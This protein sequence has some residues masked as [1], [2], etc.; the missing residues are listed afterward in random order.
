MRL[1]A[2]VRVCPHCGQVFTAEEVEALLPDL[3]KV[4]FNE[5]EPP[6]T[7]DVDRMLVCFHVS[8]AS[9]KRMLRVDF[10]D[11]AIF[12]GEKTSAYLGFSDEYS[13]F[14]LEKSAALWGQICPDYPMPD[15]AEEAF[16]VQKMMI[17]PSQV[18]YQREGKFKNILE[19]IFTE[20]QEA[21]SLD[22]VPF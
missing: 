1:H 20:K 2:S 12:G 13:G 14:F 18:I 5:P 7:I 17:Q 4:T 19:L 10:S 3:K 22:E 8:Q 9:G 6:E 11:G 16:E 21:V 15:S